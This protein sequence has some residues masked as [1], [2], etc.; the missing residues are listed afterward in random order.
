M[1]P[2]A[3]DGG[4]AFGGVALALATVA[5]VELELAVGQAGFVAAAA[6]ALVVDEY[7]AGGGGGV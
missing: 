6:F 5:A 3:G 2:G 1:D 4:D 7:E